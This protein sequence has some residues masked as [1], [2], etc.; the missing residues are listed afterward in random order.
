MAV[1]DARRREVFSARYRPVP[2][3]VQRV[4]EYEVQT[5]GDLVAELE[6]TGRGAGA[7]SSRATAWRGS[8]PSS[9][10]SSTPSSPGP[11]SHAPSV[12]ALV[13]LAT[14]RVEREEFEAP[15]DL[16]PL[17]LRQSDAEIDWDRKAEVG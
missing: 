13:E 6:P 17:Y 7:C 5:P 14:A 11:S 16:H 8:R 10:P 12:A 15:W 3:G 1:L 4:S 2:G 9:P